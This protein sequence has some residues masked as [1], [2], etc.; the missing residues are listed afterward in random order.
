MD[1][2]AQYPMALMAFAG[3]ALGALTAA[4][5]PADVLKMVMPVMLLAIG[6]YFALK[7][8]LGD[9]DRLRRLAPFTFGVTAVPLIGFYDGIF[10]PG[11]GSFFML[12]FVLLAG[13]GLLKATAHTKLLNLGS[14]FGAFLVFVATGSVLW[15]LGIIMALGQ[16]IGAQAGARFAMR[17][18]ARIIR[19][20]LVLSCL[21]MAVRLLADPSNPLRLALGF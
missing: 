6:L 16:V 14:N 9:S 11:T 19:P 2:K 5:V 13:F 8:S 4:L 21:A 12:A 18:G 15:K 10:G 3:G 20:L 1:L 7:P 17:N